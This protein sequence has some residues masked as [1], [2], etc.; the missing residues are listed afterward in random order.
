MGLSPENTVESVRLAFETD[1]RKLLNQI[2]V[3]TLVLHRSEDRLVQVEAGRYLG[4]HIP[5]ARY[6][7]LPGADYL[8]FAGDSTRMLD[9]IAHFLTG[10]RQPP[11]EDVVTQAILFTDIVG[12][13]QLA[14]RLGHRQWTA[15]SDQHNAMVR[16]V[17]QR[18]GGE[19]IKTIGDGFLATF[20]SAANAVTSGTEICAA[21]THMDLQVRAGVHLGEVEMRPN[22]IV[23]LPVNI[24]KRICDLAG[25][26]ETL[27]SRAVADSL[28]AHDLGFQDRGIHDLK[29]VPGS[30]Q[31]FRPLP[32]GR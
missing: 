18:F 26:S 6:V 13:T 28:A 11:S 25:P 14:A 20:E 1:N 31:L 12:S 2:T 21:A 4:D 23:G 9:E 22:D 15:L 8:F 29:G 3:R 24:A 10:S 30:W 7:E 27:V 17:L 16:N 5:N 19:E 32:A